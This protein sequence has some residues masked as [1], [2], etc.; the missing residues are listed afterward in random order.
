MKT[1]SGENEHTKTITIPV[2]MKT[3]CL[4]VKETHP[5]INKHKRQLQSHR[6]FDER[7]KTQ[8]RYASR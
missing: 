3:N 1:D 5:Q 8:T 2:K 7:T 4:E 6:Y